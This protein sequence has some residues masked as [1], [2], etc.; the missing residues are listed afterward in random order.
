MMREV[1]MLG[2]W[3]D[4]LRS[5]PAHRDRALSGTRMARTGRDVAPVRGEMT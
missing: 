1:V 4:T 5:N 3:G 2:V